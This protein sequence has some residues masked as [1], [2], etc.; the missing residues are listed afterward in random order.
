VSVVEG[1]KRG[2]MSV[3][4][5]GGGSNPGFVFVKQEDLFYSHLTVRETLMFT[6]RLRLPRTMSRKDKRAY[7]ERMIFKMGL[8]DV[9]DTLVSRRTHTYICTRTD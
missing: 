2:G 5:L 7:V 6:A 8:T 3:P 9:A 4:G 1:E